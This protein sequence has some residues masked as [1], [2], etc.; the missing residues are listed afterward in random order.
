MSIPH[1]ENI[2]MLQI[3]MPQPRKRVI[4]LGSVQSPTS[5]KK[6]KRKKVLN[7]CKAEKKNS[8]E[9]KRDQPRASACKIGRL[10][11]GSLWSLPLVIF[12]GCG[13]RVERRV[14]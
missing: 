8:H 9:V 14:R 2:A 7:K 5:E 1:F 11:P 10:D 13:C 6:R 12:V 4:I 3:G